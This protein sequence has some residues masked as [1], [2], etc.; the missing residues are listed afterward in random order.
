MATTKRNRQADAIKQKKA[1]L[2][3]KIEE[4]RRVIKQLK[5]ELKPH[6]K[7]EK[8]LIDQK[9][10]LKRTNKKPNE[11]SLDDN[12]A[13]IKIVSLSQWSKFMEMIVEWQK[14][15][16]IEIVPKKTTHIEFDLR[17]KPIILRTLVKILD[18][19]IKV[20]C[21]SERK[22]LIYLSR[23]TNLGNYECLKKA[24]YRERN[25]WEKTFIPKNKKWGHKISNEDSS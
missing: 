1:K 17:A 6:Q 24:V 15:T 25:R 16:T 23:H 12:L 13:I 7:A 3:R 8:V 11:H 14:Y 20:F 19:E 5:A 22:V 4:E 21:V 9:R 10:Q 18:N 2:N